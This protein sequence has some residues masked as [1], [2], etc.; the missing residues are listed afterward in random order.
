MIGLWGFCVWSLFCG[1]VLGVLSFQFLQSSRCGRESWLLHW[2]KVFYV[3]SSR[4]CGL[5]WWLTVFE[6][7]SGHTH[8]PKLAWLWWKGTVY[9]MEWSLVAEFWSGVR[10][11]SGKSRMECSYDVMW[12]E[13]VRAC[14][15]VCVIH[16]YH[17]IT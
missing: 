14:V 11:W 13:C 7:F 9:S 10:F 1:A 6:A 12:C 5:V 16:N 3:S 15:R 4:C 2:L 8:L 17:K